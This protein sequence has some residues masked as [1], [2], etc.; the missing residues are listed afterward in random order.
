MDK[1]FL[2]Y[3]KWNTSSR[4]GHSSQTIDAFWSLSGEAIEEYK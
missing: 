1:N 4:F 3:K 2:R